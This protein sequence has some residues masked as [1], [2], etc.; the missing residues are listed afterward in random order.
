[1]FYRLI[2]ESLLG[3]TREGNR[4]HIKPCIPTDWPSYTINYRTGETVYRIEITQN[5]N[6]K[7]TLR[8][9]GVLQSENS[10]V[11]VDDGMEHL[12]EMGMSMKG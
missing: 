11:I 8:L 3:I 10:F 7:N 2:I 1:M 12:V 9:D 4:L 6:A 5:E